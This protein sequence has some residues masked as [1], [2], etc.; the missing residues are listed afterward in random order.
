MIYQKPGLQ[1]RLSRA[2]PRPLSTVP[3]PSWMSSGCWGREAPLSLAPPRGC[4]QKLEAGA[5]ALCFCQLPTR[6]RSRKEALLSFPPP[7]RFPP[8]PPRTK[9]ASGKG[10]RAPRSGEGWAQWGHSRWITCAKVMQAPRLPNETPASLSL[11]YDT[12]FCYKILSE[13]PISSCVIS[14]LINFNDIK[15]T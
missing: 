2:D 14:F 10:V 5:T 3:A 9:E 11:F 7:S 13:L 4:R 8:V 1:S 6:G 12:L 15:Y